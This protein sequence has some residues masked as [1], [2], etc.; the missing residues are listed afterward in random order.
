MNNIAE[1][2]TSDVVGYK[3]IQTIKNDAQRKEVSINDNYS[4]TE[5]KKE[6]DTAK[7]HS[8]AQLYTSM[9]RLIKYI[10]WGGAVLFLVFIVWWIYLQYSI[11]FEAHSD[12][13][14]SRIRELITK[15]ESL[16]NYI[17]TAGIGYAGGIARTFFNND[18]N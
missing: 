17:L 13:E 3:K 10:I 11:T 6:Y 15:L 7:D 5:L 4:S 18:R 9:S 12:N 8:S 2:I 16:F 1:N 14:L